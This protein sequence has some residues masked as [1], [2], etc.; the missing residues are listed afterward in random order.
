MRAFCPPAQTLVEEA[1][2]G[3]AALARADPQDLRAVQV[4][5]EGG[6]LATLAEGDLVDPERG[7]APDGVPA[8]HP[9]DDP[10]QQVGQGRGRQPQ[11]LSRGL[12]GHDL[13]QGA[14]APLQAVGDARIGRRPG[15]LLLYAPVSR[16]LDF[17]RGIPEHDA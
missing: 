17:L 9:R 16:A 7:Q 11:D 4:I 2:D 1:I 5:D 8:A 12:L 14:E 13:T 6:E 3:V 15:D 10:M